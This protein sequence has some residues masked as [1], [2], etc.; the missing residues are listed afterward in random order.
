M[1]EKKQ[2]VAE[3]NVILQ[4]VQ[5]YSQGKRLV[6]NYKTE[7]GTLYDGFVQAGPVVFEGEIVEKVGPAEYIAKKARYTACTT[8]PAAW[9]FSGQKIEAEIGGY[10]WIKYPVLK[11]G[12]HPRICLTCHTSTTKK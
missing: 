10:A 4:N 1:S 11:S 3:G 8:C 9:S 7:K 5:V 2:V 12:R 6:Y